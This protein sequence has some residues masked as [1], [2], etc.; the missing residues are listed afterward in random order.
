MKK[1]NIEQAFEIFKQMFEGWVVV[2]KGGEKLQIEG[3]CNKASDFGVFANNKYYIPALISHLE[4]TK[5]MNGDTVFA[6]DN[7]NHQVKGDYIGKHEDTHVVVL[8]VF[9]EIRV[10][11]HVK[12]DKEPLR[13]TIQEATEMLRKGEKVDGE[14]EII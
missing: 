3:V 6:W 7:I 11:K 5:P 12:L 13:L 1:H 14:F 8:W 9:D 4:Q 10:F 2:T